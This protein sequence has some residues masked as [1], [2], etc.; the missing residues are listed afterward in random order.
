VPRPAQPRLNV[1]NGLYIRRPPTLKAT[2]SAGS[3]RYDVVRSYAY[4]RLGLAHFAAKRYADAQR[5]F[6][7]GLGRYAD[8]PHLLLMLGRTLIEQGRAAEA[9]S[10]LKRSAARMPTAAAEW[11]LG[12]ALAQVGDRAG[13]AAHYEAALA[14]TPA[15][16][17]DRREEIQARLK[18]M[19]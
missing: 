8:D 9:V 17:S 19:R 3:P 10:P 4:L 11:R 12:D 7:A 2:G 18:A 15:L 14:F 16:T 13:A 1:G 5:V 6:E